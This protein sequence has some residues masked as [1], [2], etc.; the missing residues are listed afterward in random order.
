VDS[1]TIPEGYVASVEPPQIQIRA[2]EV[3]RGVQ[4]RLALQPRSMIITDLP[5]QHSV[6]SPE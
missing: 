1:G 5:K 3:V 6:S 2:G 4:I